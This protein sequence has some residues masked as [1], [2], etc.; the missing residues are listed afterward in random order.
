MIMDREDW[1][2]LEQLSLEE[3]SNRYRKLKRSLFGDPSGKIKTF[4]IIS[5]ENPLGWEDS[6]EEEFKAQF[7][8]WTQDPRKY[9]AEKLKQMKVTELLHVIQVTGEAALKYGGFN[10]VPL[11][12]HYGD[13]E[14]SF[15][16][17]N[18]SLEDAK[19][20]ARSYGQISFF[21]G[22]VSTQESLIYYYKTSNACVTYKLIEAS[23]TVT[24]ED[25]AE[26]FFSKFGLKFRIN[27]REFGDQVPEIINQ[28]SFEES[29]DDFRGF[30]GRAAKRRDAFRVQD[31]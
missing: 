30:T 27:M 29:F 23:K 13:L 2:E 15:L 12:G 9:N 11:K 17:L 6:T 5:P 19:V 8:K 18:L 14:H 1:E 28:K 21:F 20:I 10:Y 24:Y 7:Q 3:N 16:I 4:A 25:E 26:D 22:E 31:N